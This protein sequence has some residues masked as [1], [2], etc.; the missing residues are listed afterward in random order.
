[1]YSTKVIAP[2]KGRK[3]D[4]GSGDW[5]Q[6]SQLKAIT[7]IHPVSFFLFF[8][9][10]FESAC[11]LQSQGLKEG[12]DPQDKLSYNTIANRHGQDPTWVDAAFIRVKWVKVNA[13][14]F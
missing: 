13:Q 9:F 1:M 12:A 7:I 6:L 4:G 11:R 10:L 8:F 14:T 3:Q 5:M 2:S